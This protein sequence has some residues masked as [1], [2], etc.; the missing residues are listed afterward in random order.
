M[1]AHA[2]SEGQLTDALT[3]LSHALDFFFSRTKLNSSPETPSCGDLMEILIKISFIIHYFLSFSYVDIF[4]LIRSINSDAVICE[5]IY[6][7]LSIRK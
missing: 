4:K 3:N 2:S 6:I 5:Y 7:Q 1:L